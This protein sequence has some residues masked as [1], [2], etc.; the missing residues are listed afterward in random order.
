M[1]SPFERSPFAVPTKDA[2][3]ML[4]RAA[5]YCT[6]SPSGVLQLPGEVGRRADLDYYRG[7][8]VAR[9][10][11]LTPPLPEGSRVVTTRSVTA[12]LRGNGGTPL[13][14][15]QGRVLKIYRALYDV[16]ATRWYLIL[17]EDDGR[18]F[19]DPLPGFFDPAHFELS[20]G[21]GAAVHTA[22]LPSACVA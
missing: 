13:Q 10:G 2:V 16:A 7:A 17:C 18:S 8:L 15:P 11:S 5:A 3:D 6:I 4:A 20:N 22:Q 14:L 1:R 19:S 12:F 9:L 21:S